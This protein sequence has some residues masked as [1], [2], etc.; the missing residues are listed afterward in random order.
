MHMERGIFE[1]KASVEA[2]SLY[3][4]LCAL[5]DQGQ[6]PSLERARVYWNGTD[7]GLTRAVEELIHRGVIERIDPLSEQ[8]SLVVTPKTR[9]H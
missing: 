9:W 5:L 7:E 1:L 2:T 8:V 3:I 6:S 4:L